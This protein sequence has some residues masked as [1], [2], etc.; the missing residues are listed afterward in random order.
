MRISAWSRVV[1]PL[2]KSKCGHIEALRVWSA[3]RLGQYDKAKFKHAGVEH[4]NHK[5]S[6]KCMLWNVYAVS[7]QLHLSAKGQWGQ[8]L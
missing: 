2:K 6:H 1:T 8:S 7:Y 3:E 4:E 5:M